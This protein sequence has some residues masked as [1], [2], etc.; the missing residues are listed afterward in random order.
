MIQKINSFF[1]LRYSAP[2]E[3]STSTCIFCLVFADSLVS[4]P[5]LSVMSLAGFEGL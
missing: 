1:G 3:K 5:T 2:K 4:G